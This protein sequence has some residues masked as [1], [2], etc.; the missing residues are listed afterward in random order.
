M[1]FNS[2]ETHIKNNQ[3]NR[4]YELT[5]L[6]FRG[7]AGYND[8]Y[9]GPMRS[10]F[11]DSDVTENLLKLVNAGRSSGTEF[12]SVV[13]Q[14]LKPTIGSTASK[15]IISNGW[16]ESR[17]MFLMTIRKAESGTGAGESYLSHL[18][19]GFTDHFDVSLQTQRLP[20]DMRLTLN[21]V[22]T[23]RET[24]TASAFGNTTMQTT[25]VSS[26][27]LFSKQYAAP[28][29]FRNPNKITGMRPS[30]IFSNIQASGIMEG[31]HPDTTST[32]YRFDNR[33]ILASGTTDVV[34]YSDRCTNNN[35]STYMDKTLKA[36]SHGI[37][38]NTEMD[39]GYPVADDAV[40]NSYNYAFDSDASIG[41]STPAM[42][43]LTDITGGLDYGTRGYLTFKDLR[44]FFGSRVDQILDRPGNVS[45]ISSRQMN[46]VKSLVAS[47]QGFGA[48]T[49][50]TEIALILCHSVPTY[51]LKCGI[52]EYGFISSNDT[53]SSFA[54]SAGFDT[55]PIV[56]D[57]GF[58]TVMLK[59][60]CNSFDTNRQMSLFHDMIERELLLSLSHQNAQK[61]LVKV[62]CSL[63]GDTVIDVTWGNE[64]TEQFIIPTFCDQLFSPMATM[65]SSDLNNLSLD[66]YSFSEMM[67]GG[68]MAGFDKSSL[69]STGFGNFDRK[70]PLNIDTS[71]SFS[72][73]LRQT[74]NQF[75]NTGN[76]NNAEYVL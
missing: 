75:S 41:H 47:M 25:L 30:D 43:F 46:S 5:D 63:C 31:F 60:F 22:F 29:S 33:S 49:K 61:L 66:I 9:M 64:P 17:A 19:V 68:P 15:S 65:N 16:G 76:N 6:R 42:R 34:K 51:M 21:H 20:D 18:F 39:N 72:S 62:T 37:N 8:M 11:S 59:L 73:A 44:G 57:V 38:N 27:Q 36:I 26:H 14:L 53:R 45:I 7:R 3:N 74:D 13:N 35:A 24:P 55:K 32:N 1:T 10:D 67:S 58:G 69:D 54:G 48:K 2:F 28:D 4:S 56:S 23:F 71:T 12:S 70:L 52:V 40:M 50:Q